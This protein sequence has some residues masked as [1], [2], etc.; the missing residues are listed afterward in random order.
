MSD[1]EN[2]GMNWTV[3][4]TYVSRFEDIAIFFWRGPESGAAMATPAT[5][6]AP[7]LWHAC[8]L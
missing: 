3:S 1:H 2:V 8:V 4:D 7:V 5:P 6:V